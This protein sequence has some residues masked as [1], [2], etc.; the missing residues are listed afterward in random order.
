LEEEIGRGAFSKVYA[1]SPVPSQ[2]GT[3]KVAVKI[4]KTRVELPEERLL[5]KIEGQL[6]AMSGSKGKQWEKGLLERRKSALKTIITNQCSGTTHVADVMREVNLMK[7]CAHANILQVIGVFTSKRCAAIVLPKCCLDLSHF[8]RHQSEPTDHYRPL[9]DEMDALRFTKDLLSALSYL[10]DERNIV[11]NDI[12]PANCALDSYDIQT[13]Q[14]MLCDF[15]LARELPRTLTFFEEPER[16]GGTV[17]YLSPEAVRGYR[18]RSADVWASGC[19]LFEL[20]ACQKFHKHFI[21]FAN[22]KT[23]KNISVSSDAYMHLLAITSSKAIRESLEKDRLHDVSCHLERSFNDDILSTL[24]LLFSDVKSRPSAGHVLKQPLFK[25]IPP[26]SGEKV[27]KKDDRDDN[28]SSISTTCST[29]KSS[30]SRT[31]SRT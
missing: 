13:A 16:V 5:N 2:D 29:V 11:H 30:K 18:G 25:D 26:T 22:E 24:K 20:L 31:F 12:K 6:N 27:A 3:K 1:A 17:Y 23:G 14:L 15:G 8:V 28:L 21:A 9:Q 19:V 10:H 7:E 4:I